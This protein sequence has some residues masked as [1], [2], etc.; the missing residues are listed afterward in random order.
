MYK[1]ELRRFEEGGLFF[2]EDPRQYN[3]ELRPK[4]YE[5]P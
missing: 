3:L 5:V 2:T 1:V 4:G